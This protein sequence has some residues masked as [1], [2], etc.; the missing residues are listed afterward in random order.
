MRERG[1]G[2]DMPAG[3]LAQRKC[4]KRPGILAHGTWRQAWATVSENIIRSSGVKT[5]PSSENEIKY[6]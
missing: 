5:R 4:D 1:D 6:Y 2:T 3:S